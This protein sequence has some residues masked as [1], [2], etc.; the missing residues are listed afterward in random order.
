M[1]PDLEPRRRPENLRKPTSQP[2]KVRPQTFDRPVAVTVNEEPG[3]SYARQVCLFMGVIL[4]FVGLIGFVMDNFLAAHLSYVHNVIHVI[5]GILAV[6]F[7]YYGL[8]AAKNF[9]YTFA[10]IYGLLGVAGFIVGTQGM[11]TVGH[12]GEDRFLWK[13]RP[14]VLELGTTD[15]VIHILVAA[16][17]LAGA[18][19]TSKRKPKASLQ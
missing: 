6:G 1:E 10:A 4:F 18:I 12:I 7:G 3:V 16:I 11:S 19:Y 2:T 13:I 14:E 9:S 5:S 17:F 15:H 8:Q